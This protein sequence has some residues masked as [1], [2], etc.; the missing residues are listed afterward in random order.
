MNIALHQ[1]YVEKE[2]GIAVSVREINRRPPGSCRGCFSK[3]REGR[4]RKM[5]FFWKLVLLGI[6]S[7]L[8][9]A[10]AS[11]GALAEDGQA[12]VIFAVM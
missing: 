6:L 4:M 12:K 8:A 7:I 2:Q 10:L 1:I 9:V 3:K 11:E 5:N